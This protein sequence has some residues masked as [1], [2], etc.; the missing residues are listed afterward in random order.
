M[1]KKVYTGQSVGKVNHFFSLK[2]SVDLLVFGSSRANH[3]IDNESLNIS[4][5]NIGVDGT[6][7]G[8]S[9]ALISTLKKKDQI[10]LVHID[11]ASL[12]DS[13]YN[14]SDMMGLINMIQRSDDVSAFI[15]NFFPNEI[16]ISRIFNSYIYNSK[17]LGILKNSL[18]PSYDYSE[19]CGYD[20]LYPNQEQREIFE[21]MLKSD[22]LKLE[23][24]K[25][26]VNEVKINP[27]INKFIDLIIDYSG[28]NNSRLIFFTSPTLKRNHFNVQSI[29]KQYFASKNTSYYDYSDFFKKYNVDYWKDFTHMSA[30]GATA[31]TKA[32]KE[33]ILQAN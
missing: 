20:P 4:S 1:D 28:N 27:L 19:Y 30:D 33:E 16:Y 15:Y 32:F 14:G 26:M 21:K 18:A 7:I 12:Y 29:T 17:V 11:H 3:H 10:L 23:Q 5:F 22:S 6:K 2:D 31:F 13:E 8:Y 9:A 24:D 25:L